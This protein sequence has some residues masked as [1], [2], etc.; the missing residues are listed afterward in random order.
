MIEI[1]GAGVVIFIL[2]IIIKMHRCK[3][4]PD[5]NLRIMEERF[6]RDPSEEN[7]R[8]LTSARC[9]VNNKKN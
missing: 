1:I 6:R 4:D 2:W 9:R 3:T 7:A 5:Y 8:T